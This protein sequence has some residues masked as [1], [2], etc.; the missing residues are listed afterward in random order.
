MTEQ[1]ILNAALLQYSKH[2]YQGATMRKIA[3]QVGVK[4]ASIYYFFDNKED[5]FLKAFQ[6]ILDNHH[7][8]MNNALANHRDEPVDQIFIAMLEA[9]VEHHSADKVEMSSYISLITAPIPEIKIHLQEYMLSFNEWLTVSLENLVFKDYPHT[10]AKQVNNL[11]KQFVLLG[12]GLFWGINL[13]TND[14]LV[15][16]IELASQI[17]IS[18]FNDLGHSDTTN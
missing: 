14:S 4:A 16:Q 13:Y 18:M 2:G 6:Q 10:S 12:N 9:I 15:E 8:A 5:L 7:H 17:I 1:Q 3:E 11:I